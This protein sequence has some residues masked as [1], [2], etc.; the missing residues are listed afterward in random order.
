[1]SSMQDLRERMGITRREVSDSLGVTEQTIV[2]AETK[3]MMSLK[4]LEAL[5]DYYGVSTDFI[6]DRDSRK[7]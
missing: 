4:L 7:A 1:M 2:N 6:L 3:G 5:A